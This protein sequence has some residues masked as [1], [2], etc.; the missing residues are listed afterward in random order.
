M[1]EI[2]ASFH[3]LFMSLDDSPCMNCLD[4]EVQAS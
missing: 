4:W 3:P 2:V 1:K